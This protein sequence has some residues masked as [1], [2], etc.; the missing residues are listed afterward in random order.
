MRVYIPVTRSDVERRV[1]EGFWSIS[2]RRAWAVNQQLALAL[3][4]EDEEGREYIASL[5]AAHESPSGLAL[6]ADVATAMLGDEGADGSVQVS[7][8][9]RDHDVACL[10][11]VDEEDDDSL[12]W[13]APTEAAALLGH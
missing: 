7:G 12:L 9:L 10:L 2:A 3:P 11:R 13:F 4:E 8:V 5:T 1:E 6:A